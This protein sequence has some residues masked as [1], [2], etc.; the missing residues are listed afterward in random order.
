M[1]R[2]VASVSYFGRYG[3][4]AFFLLSCVGCSSCTDVSWDESWTMQEF[5]KANGYP[6]WV[7]LRSP[8]THFESLDKYYKGKEVEIV[9]EYFRVKTGFTNAFYSKRGEAIG[10]DQSTAPF[11]RINARFVVSSAVPPL[12]LNV[13]ADD[14]AGVE[15]ILSSGKASINSSY[16]YGWKPLHFAVQ[17]GRESIAELLVT[18]GADVNT[19]T[20]E[21]WTPLHGA[22]RFGS[23]SI[24]ELLINNGAEVNATTASK[25]S[26]LHEA[27]KS[28]DIEIVK[29]LV[30]RG[31]ERKVKD[32]NNRTPLD[33]A[34]NE[35]IIDFL[36]K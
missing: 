2:A 33:V 27:A 15:S 30:A 10:M 13:I 9:L 19:T 22:V 34:D 18:E 36:R 31:A 5:I 7:Y 20:K 4:V 16:Q 21:G 35:E 6:Q 12:I 28:G 24:V 25:W 29:I 14:T 26:V 32:K 8:E 17:L 3:V 1:T 11:M 23:K